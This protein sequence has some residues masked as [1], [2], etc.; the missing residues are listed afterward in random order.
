MSV[1]I[2]CMLKTVQLVAIL[3]FIQS[4]HVAVAGE[5]FSSRHCNSWD[6]DGIVSDQT[7]GHVYGFAG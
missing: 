3:V 7:N 6:A 5:F 1:S 4:G 2:G